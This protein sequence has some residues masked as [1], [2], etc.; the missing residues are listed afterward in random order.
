MTGRTRKPLPSSVP[1]VAPPLPLPG[2]S[3]SR[4]S[5]TLTMQTRA[6]STL[7]VIMLAVTGGRERTGHQLGRLL[8]EAGFA[9]WTVTDTI[10]P[11]HIIEAVAQ[12]D[13]GVPEPG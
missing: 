6:A 12:G 10:G 4:T 8:A 3:S 9:N 13:T 1:S 5:S 7:D 11:L 2:C